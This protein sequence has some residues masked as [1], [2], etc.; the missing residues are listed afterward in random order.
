MSLNKHKIK[1]LSATFDN[2]VIYSRVLGNIGYIHITY[3]IKKTDV[4]A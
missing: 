2:S 4:N 1:W 3:S